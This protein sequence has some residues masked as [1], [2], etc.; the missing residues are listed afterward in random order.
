MPLHFLLDLF[1]LENI[2]LSK[3]KRS[4]SI[5]H[6]TFF[7]KWGRSISLVLRL[8]QIWA[9]LPSDPVQVIINFQSGFFLILFFNYGLYSTFYISCRCNFFFNVLIM[10][11]NTSSKCLTHYFW[12]SMQVILDILE[13]TS[14]T[15]FSVLLSDLGKWILLFWVGG[16]EWGCVWEGFYLAS[17]SFLFALSVV[18]SWITT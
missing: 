1:C 8:N 9:S 4:Q 3:M 15:P 6:L 13:F 10:D 7:P 14:C 12:E 2:Y 17:K 11:M 5:F 16:G 18:S